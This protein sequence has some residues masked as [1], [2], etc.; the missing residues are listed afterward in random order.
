MLKK[1]LQF[2]S[3]NFLT[4]LSMAPRHPR[5]GAVI[6]F[7]LGQDMKRNILIIMLMLAGI[8]LAAPSNPVHTETPQHYWRTVRSAVST[9]DTAL[10]DT[11]K[12]WAD[13]PAAAYP[14]P[15]EFNNI[16]LRFRGNDT[17][18]S[19]DY[20]VY[21]YSEGDDA[22]KVCSGSVSN[23]ADNQAAT[24]GGYYCDTVSATSVWATDVVTAD[25]AGADGMGRVVFDALGYSYIFVELTSISASDNISVDI[26]GM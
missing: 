9:S 1:Y 19:A 21:L 11:T 18:A 15:E 14:I 2:K 5:R 10:D 12:D 13:K 20:V 8:L 25:N 3:C 6:N 23:G 26:R 16:E 22:V 17:G 24:L 4:F 7:N